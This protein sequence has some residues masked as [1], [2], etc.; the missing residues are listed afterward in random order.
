MA[1]PH[2]EDGEGPTSEPPVSEH[3][4]GSDTSEASAVTGDAASDGTGETAG[5]AAENIGGEATGETTSEAAGSGLT[6]TNELWRLLLTVP[7]VI[8][9]VFALWYPLPNSRL[10][11]MAPSWWVPATELFGLQQ[12]WAMFS[13]DPPELTLDVE[14]VI[15]DAEGE[16]WVINVPRP[17]PLIGSVYS[18]RY[19]KWEER[20][21]P[22]AMNPEWPNAARWFATK[23][24]QEGIDPKVVQLRRSWTM[25]DLPGR[26]HDPETYSF[27]F[28]TYEVDS[29]TSTF[30]D[31]ELNPNTQNPNAQNPNQAPPTTAAPEAAGPVLDPS[32]TGASTTTA[33]PDNTTATE[34]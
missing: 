11:A 8:G 20:I 3:I 4:D 34:E 10:K 29:G 33:K 26:P 1:E 31:P 16:E 28:F 21:Y 15:T 7:I 17:N 9:L 22:V 24:R 12:N 19:R 5:D 14:A 32:S 2:P 18:E 23:A 6:D 25:T 13:P 27:V 30:H